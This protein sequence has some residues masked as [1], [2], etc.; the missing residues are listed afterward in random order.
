MTAEGA[1]SLAL[2]GNEH[3]DRIGRAL[4]HLI[5]RQHPDGTF[6]LSWSR[7]HASAIFRSVRALRLARSLELT[8][9]RP[10]ASRAVER[11]TD[12]LR[13][14][15]NPDGGWGHLPGSASDEVS[16]AF[17]LIALTIAAPAAHREAVARGIRYLASRQLPDG[18]FD[19]PTDE[20]GPRPIPYNVPHGSLGFVLTGLNFVA[21]RGR[22][23]HFA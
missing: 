14:T 11:S 16:T 22:T 6:E 4:N 23:P 5:Q 10:A 12:L 21:S 3:A 9:V 15:Q 1:I 17:S 19:C 20:V 2:A 8:N 13:A 18:A 7:S